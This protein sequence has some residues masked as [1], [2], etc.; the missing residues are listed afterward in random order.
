MHFQ[1]RYLKGLTLILCCILCSTNIVLGQTKQAAE[2]YEAGLSA[3][4]NND[5]QKTIQLLTYYHSPI[6][7]IMVS[8]TYP[9]NS[10][11][12]WSDE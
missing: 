5:A 8:I 3:L 4:N 1:L 2:T 12:R 9:Y 7:L 10:R 11:W 6:D